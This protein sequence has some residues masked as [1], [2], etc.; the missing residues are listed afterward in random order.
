LGDVAIALC[1]YR[2]LVCL[3]QI[4]PSLITALQ[5]TPLTAA[6]R[7]GHEK[8]HE[9]DRYGN[10]DHDDSRRYGRNGGQQG[11][12]PFVFLQGFR[13]GA[14]ARRSALRTDGAKPTAPSRTRRSPVTDTFV[15]REARMADRE[16]LG[17]VLL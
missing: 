10:H 9:H 2:S 6:H 14:Y 16:A 4:M 1:A 15:V 5:A 13:S 7:H 12:A 11:V 3:S 17:G 8:H